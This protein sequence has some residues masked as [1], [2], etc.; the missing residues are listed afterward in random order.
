MENTYENIIFF[1]PSPHHKHFGNLS[2]W[3]FKGYEDVSCCLVVSL[4]HTD[5]SWERR[6]T[7]VWIDV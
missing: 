6:N 5:Q 7:F 1:V 3:C 4:S 2:T